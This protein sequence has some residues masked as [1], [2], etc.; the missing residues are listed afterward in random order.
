MSVE[1]ADLAPL[2]ARVSKLES[3]LRYLYE[4]LNIELGPEIHE[5]DDPKIV[6]LI[7]KGKKQK[8]SRCI[9]KLPTP[10]LPS[11]KMPSKKYKNDWDCK[12]KSGRCNRPLFIN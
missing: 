5:P 8:P 12:I 7:K 4:K 9:G 2:R 1:E 6:D 10:G 11:Q 3:Q